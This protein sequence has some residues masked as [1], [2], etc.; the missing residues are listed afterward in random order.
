MTTTF[1]LNIYGILPP[2]INKDWANTLIE[3]GA[4]RVFADVN[5]YC[6]FILVK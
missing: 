6:K 1:N 4:E 2:K 3:A 5:E